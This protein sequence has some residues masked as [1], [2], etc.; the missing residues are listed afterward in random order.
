MSVVD[1]IAYMD[2]A[3]V[4]TPF[5]LSALIYSYSSVKKIKKKR[6]KL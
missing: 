2:L 3:L 1:Y 4:L 5:T 6:V